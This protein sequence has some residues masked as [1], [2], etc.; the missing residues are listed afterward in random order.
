MTFAEFGNRLHP[1]KSPPQL[2]HFAGGYP[3]GCG[4]G[5]NPFE[6]SDVTD[7]FLNL[8][9]V[10]PGLKK[11]LHDIIAAVQFLDVHYRHRQPAAQQPRS[12]RRRAFVDD[13]D[14]RDPF[15]AG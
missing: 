4:P 1:G 7:I 10:F 8:V 6:V 15:A 12:H 11:V 13:A 2:H 5:D 3:S 14:Q 9:K